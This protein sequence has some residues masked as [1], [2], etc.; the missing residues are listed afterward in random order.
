[1]T[2]WINEPCPWLPAIDRPHT[3]ADLKPHGKTRDATFYAAALRYAQSHWRAGFPAQA[4]LQCNRALACPLPGSEPV[5][6]EFPLPYQALLWILLHR[7]EGQF[8]G[9]PR[10]HWQHL[11]TRMVE[12][13]KDLRTWRAWA[14]WYLAKT[15]LPAIEFPPDIQQIRQENLAEPEFTTIRQQLDR[16]SP[17]DDTAR[18]LE[19]LAE[20]RRSV[21]Q[22]AAG[23]LPPAAVRIRPIPAEELPTVIALA[24]EIWHQHYPGIISREQIDYMLTVWYQTDA[25]R[26]EMSGR[27]VVYALIELPERG[28]VGYLAHEPQL[29]H[30]VLFLSK[31]YLRATSRGMGLGRIALDWV[32]DQAAAQGFH[33]LRLRVNR[34]NASAIQSYLRAGFRILEDV[35]SDIGN[36]FVMDDY[37]MERPVRG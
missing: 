31:L 28:A 18:W 29:G 1:M 10:R 9:N 36:G 20:A 3:A 19:A 25:M 13:H 16:L 5:L 15:V 24:H 2:P 17:A 14:C 22:P 27:G 34:A 8:I 21:G 12:P 23:P 11:A 33:T 4:I 37:L 30:E 35:C 32:R 6:Q 26:R 7:R